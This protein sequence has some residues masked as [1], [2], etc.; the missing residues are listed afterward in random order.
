MYGKDVPNRSRF[1]FNGSYVRRVRTFPVDVTLR[2]IRTTSTENSR[3]SHRG[4]DRPYLKFLEGALA[5]FGTATNVIIS[6]VE[7]M[8]DT[9]I[10]C[11]RAEQ[12]VNAELFGLPRH[13]YVVTP[14][15]DKQVP[16]CIRNIVRRVHFSTIFRVLAR[17]NI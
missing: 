14:A 12:Y 1:H 11:T 3:Q 9:D 2:T 16:A 7:K 8:A 13:S 4:R 17:K 15:R 5:A 10:Q 6:W